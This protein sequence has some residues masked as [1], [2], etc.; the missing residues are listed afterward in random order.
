[1]QI[2]AVSTFFEVWLLEKDFADWATFPFRRSVV[3]F[4]IW[5]LGLALTPIPMLGIVVAPLLGWFANADYFDYMPLFS[6]TVDVWF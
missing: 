4:F 3:G 1:M 2:V 5:A 6:P